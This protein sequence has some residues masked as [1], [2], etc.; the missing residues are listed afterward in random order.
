MKLL[1]IDTATD[2][3]SCALYLDGDTQDRS[4]I[5]PRQ[6]TALILPMVCFFI[7]CPAFAVLINDATPFRSHAPCCS[8]TDFLFKVT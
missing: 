3:C 1:A 5:A 7:R 8:T 2:A 6:H 4:V